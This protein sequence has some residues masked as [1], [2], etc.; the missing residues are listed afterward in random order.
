MFIEPPPLNM[1]V[2]DDQ[3]KFTGIWMRWLSSIYNI[4]AIK[5]SSLQLGKN[6]NGPVIK[7]NGTSIYIKNYNDTLYV[8][9]GFGGGFSYGTLTMGI[10]GIGGGFYIQFWNVAGTFNAAIRFIGT[11]NR[12]YVLP[13][14]TGTALMS[15]VGVD[16]AITTAITNI[17]TPAINVAVGLSYDAAITVL[18]TAIANLRI[19]LE[20]WVSERFITEAELEEAQVENYAALPT[21]A[22]NATAAAAG[23]AIGGMYRTNADPSVLCVR[24]A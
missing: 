12:E 22:D 3:K 21:A 14:D 9:L 10:G 24:T 17:I 2:E 1:I 19:E 8:P 15:N 6:A 4:S 7:M 11:A 20:R 18:N 13:N 23:V 16:S 5:S